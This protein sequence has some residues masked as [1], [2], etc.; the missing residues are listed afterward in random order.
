MASSQ[1]VRFCRSFDGAQIAYAVSGSGP[2]VVMLPSWLTH[3]ES[4]WRSVAWQPWLEVLSQRY[5]LIRYD[6]RGCGLSDRDVA[7]LS[8]DTEALNHSRSAQTADHKEAARAFVEKRAPAFT[9]R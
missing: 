7:D 2:P 6:P 3:R 8:F 1:R 5:A 9:G 4:Q